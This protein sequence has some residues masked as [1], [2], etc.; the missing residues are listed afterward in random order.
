MY[1]SKK[2]Q[3]VEEVIIEDTSVYACTSEDCNGWMRMQFSSAE[4]NCPLC[5]S[6]M[7]EEIRQLPKIT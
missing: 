2:P 7:H 1:F 3:E 5:G 4:T 6:S